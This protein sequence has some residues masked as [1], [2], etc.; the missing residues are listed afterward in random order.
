M[1]DVTFTLNGEEVTA[2]NSKTILDVSREQGIDIPTLCYVEGLS[3]TGACRVC[4]VEVEGSRTL[5]ASCHTPV[6]NGMV[7][8]THSEKVLKAR[9][10]IIELLQASHC[11]SCYMCSKANVCE[12]RNVAADLDGGES[13]FYARRRF[14]QIEDVS[15]YVTRDMTKCILCRRCVRVCNEIAE[16]HVFGT[17]YRGF[18]SRIVVDFDEVLNTE[19]CRDCGKCI[20]VCPTGALIAPVEDGVKKTGIP[21]IL[22][23]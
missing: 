14:S 12:M 13:R 22:K 3:P 7:I 20:P 5:V 2:D 18:D 17:A 15:P 21:F 9:K 19:A 10:M 16:K 1:S 11:G 4:V 6:G 8:S 23:G